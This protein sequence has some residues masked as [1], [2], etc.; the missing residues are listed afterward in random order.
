MRLGDVGANARKWMDKAG[1]AGVQA[2]QATGAGLDKAG[3]SL[4]KAGQATGHAVM[5]PIETGKDGGKAIARKGRSVAEHTK[6]LGRE[7]DSR[8]FIPEG[9][10]KPPIGGRMGRM[11]DKVPVGPNAFEAMSEAERKGKCPNYPVQYSIPATSEGSGIH[12]TG[13]MAGF[14]T[15]PGLLPQEYRVPGKFNYD[16]IPNLVVTPH[17]E[18]DIKGLQHTGTHL[19]E[20]GAT[21][22]QRVG[23]DGLPAHPDTGMPIIPKIPDGSFTLTAQTPMPR[24][25]SEYSLDT[26]VRTKPKDP[27]A[28]EDIESRPG[29]AGGPS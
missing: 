22:L 25:A 29:T 19:M 17:R 5:H 2:G 13:R 15:G 9:M 16:E 23:G 24:R 3:K 28:L 4:K 11:L 26:P 7:I 1:N 6:A 20:A 8:K 18:R 12:A 10:P 27:Y 21:T 14:T